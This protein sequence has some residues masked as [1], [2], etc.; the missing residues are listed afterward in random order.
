MRNQYHSAQTTQTT[1]PPNLI[2]MAEALARPLNNIN[3]HDDIL[4]LIN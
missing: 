2:P 4:S 1:L 3:S